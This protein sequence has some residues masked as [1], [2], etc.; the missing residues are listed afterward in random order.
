MM[1]VV[2]MKRIKI[3]PFNIFSFNS[4]T[5]RLGRYYYFLC[6]RRENQGSDSS[7][8]SHLHKVCIKVAEP[9]FELGNWIPSLQQVCYAHAFYSELYA[10]GCVQ[11]KMRGQ[12]FRDI[13]AWS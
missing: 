13:I 7:S 10:I 11:G 8:K 12:F 1:M 9:G 4:F 3:K 6:F 5:L 2:M